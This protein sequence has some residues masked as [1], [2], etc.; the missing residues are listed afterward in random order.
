DLVLYW[1]RA[2]STTA[3]DKTNLLDERSDRSRYLVNSG[4]L[5][6]LHVNA[7]GFLLDRSPPTRRVR[8]LL[9]TRPTPHNSVAP[10]PY[11]GLAVARVNFGGPDR[12]CV[13]GGYSLC[14]LDL[15]PLPAKPIGISTLAR[16]EGGM[17]AFN[18]PLFA[19][20]IFGAASLG[21]GTASGQSVTPIASM[22]SP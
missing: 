10:P 17:N 3:W 20:L 14:E 19:A 15:C 7:R 13:L 12:V 2:S 8:P 22:S 16:R 18:R 11:Y 4:S 5:S 6:E 21:A 9:T 1:R